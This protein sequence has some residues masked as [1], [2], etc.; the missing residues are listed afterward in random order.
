M[1]PNFVIAGAAKAGSTW[2]ADALSQHPDVFVTPYKD[3]HFFAFEGDRPY[4]TGP[5]D[6]WTNRNVITTRAQYEQLF[7]H[8]TTERAVGEGSV[9]YLCRPTSFFQMRKHLGPEA[10]VLLVLRN[11]VDRS[12]S[13][14][15]HMVRDGRETTTDFVDALG[16]ESCRISAGW[17]DLWR[18]VE[19]S[20]YARQ[21][22]AA[23]SALGQHR[24]KIWR[25]DDLQV[26][27][28]RVLRETFEFL[29]VDSS[30]RADAAVRL[31]PSGT[32]RS[33]SLNYFLRGNHMLK[34]ILRPVVPQTIRKQVFKRLNARNMRPLTFPEELRPQLAELFAEDVEALS[35]LTGLSLS[36]WLPAN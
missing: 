16:R 33:R 30:F 34:P 31:N 13:A 9:Y 2:L 28:L 36:S 12:F 29:G 23:L 35:S 17:E 20:R 5:G 6:D 14:Y 11:P 1:L 26:D 10:K 7:C 21:V 8:A 25:F 18:Y 27:H 3:C 15:G 19:L 32:P 22:E 24:V 4:F